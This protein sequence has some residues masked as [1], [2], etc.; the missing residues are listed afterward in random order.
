MSASAQ[1]VPRQN[2]NP[3]LGMN[4][5]PE[6]LGYFIQKVLAR[7]QRISPAH[8]YININ[9]TTLSIDFKKSKIPRW[10]SGYDFRLS[11]GKSR[12]TGVR[13]PVEEKI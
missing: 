2:P 3:I 7:P 13:F 12:E 9:R 10:S 1:N 4:R 11:I 6:F 8:T 5:R